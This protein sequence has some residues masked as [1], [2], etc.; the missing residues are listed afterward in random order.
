M[1]VAALAN[2]I[3]AILHRTSIAQFALHNRLYES[4]ASMHPLHECSMPILSNSCMPRCI[5]QHLF[6]LENSRRCLGSPSA[7]HIPLQLLY[8]LRLVPHSSRFVTQTQVKGHRDHRYFVPREQLQVYFHCESGYRHSEEP[9]EKPAVVF[10]FSTTEQCEL[11]GTY[12]MPLMV[13]KSFSGYVD[14]TRFI[15]PSD[16]PMHPVPTVLRDCNPGDVPS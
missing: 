1:P 4:S 10:K 15:R 8:C 3:P 7:A 13:H 2:Q 9:T 5:H 12:A 16:P 11:V 14:P 6:I